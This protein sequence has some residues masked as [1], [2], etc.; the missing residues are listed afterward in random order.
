MGRPR[1]FDMDQALNAAMTAFWTHG[2]EAT[3]MADLMK[4]MNLQKGSIYKAFHDKHDLYMQALNRYLDNGLKTMKQ[5]IGKATSPKEGIRFW[6]KEM[7]FGLCHRQDKQRGCLA[8]N[9]I[10]E[11][12]PHD[13]A[14]KERIQQQHGRMAEL[15]TRTIEKGQALGEFRQDKPAAH[16]AEALT[17]FTMGIMALSKGF[18]D[19]EATNRLTDFA[20][21]SLS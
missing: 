2:Y 13:Q 10:V 6:L 21:E 1:E 3:S 16:L 19:E 11:L 9:S 12:G 4:V 18:S 5:G 15:L 17:A 20:L 7:I 8:L 14:V